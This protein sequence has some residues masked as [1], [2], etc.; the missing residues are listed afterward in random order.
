M[1]RLT[2]EQADKLVKA[3]KTITSSVSWKSAGKNIWRLEARALTTNTKE[4]LILKGYIGK[5]NYSF[6][7][8]YNNNPI[9]KF[10]KHYRHTW[11]GIVYLKPHKHVWNEVT[12]DKEVYIPGDI[13]PQNDISHQFLAFCTECN[14]EIKGGYQTFLLEE[15]RI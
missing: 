9:R 11:N 5:V 8:L 7:L 1:T 14:V 6:V 12:E 15:T 3:K 13:D 2:K 10:T 4:I